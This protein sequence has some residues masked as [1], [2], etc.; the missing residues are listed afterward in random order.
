MQW[1]LQSVNINKY[2]KHLLTGWF[3]KL[4]IAIVNGLLPTF[5]PK[6]YTGFYKLPQKYSA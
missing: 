3:Y 2:I 4:N 1:A 5:F 6:K